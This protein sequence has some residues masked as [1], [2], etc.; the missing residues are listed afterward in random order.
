[1]PFDCSHSM[2]DPSVARSPNK[3]PVAHDLRQTSGR[4]QKLC[5]LKESELYSL[6]GRNA[7]SALSVIHIPGVEN[8]QVNILS[9]QCLDAGECV[10][11]PQAV[12]SP[13]L[14]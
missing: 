12:P 5:C 3:N 14:T 7:S 13:L 11:F 6:G 1:M 9:C 10:P 8:W 2:M 4:P